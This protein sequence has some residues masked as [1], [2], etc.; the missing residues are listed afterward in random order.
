[1][2]ATAPLVIT[3]LV[4]P[5]RWPYNVIKIGVAVLAIAVAFGLTHLR[6]LLARRK[7]VGGADE[8][9]VDV[10]YSTYGGLAS[11][12]LGHDEG[13]ICEVDGWLHFRGLR[14]TW[15]LSQNDTANAHSD[16]ITVR[17]G[18][19]AVKVL[20]LADGDGEALAT[21]LQSWRR[22]GRP[23]EPSTFP[24]LRPSRPLGPAPATVIVAVTTIFFLAAFAKL[25]TTGFRENYAAGVRSDAMHRL[26]VLTILTGGAVVAAEAYRRLLID[27]RKAFE[28]L[29]A[30]EEPVTLLRNEEARVAI[31]EL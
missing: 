9:H 8:V 29:Q 10:T 2:M 30:R 19:N 11:L 5:S 28:A 24:N 16:E 12:P 31:E 23:S 15:S 26:I 6:K 20:P 3:S 14:H 17:C 18:K 22:A 21:I 27:Q 25:M 13:W 7:F 1:M 4:G